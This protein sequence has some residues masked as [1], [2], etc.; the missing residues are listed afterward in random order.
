MTGFRAF[1]SIC[2]S[3]D[4]CYY[5]LQ[6][7]D[8]NGNPLGAWE[9]GLGTYTTSGNTL[10]RTTVLSS[11]NSGAAVSLPAGTTQ[12]WMDVPAALYPLGAMQ[13]GLGILMV[14]ENEASGTSGGSSTA[15]TAFTRVLKTVQA[16]TIAG[17]SLASNQVTLPAGTYIA[18]ASAPALGVDA[19]QAWLFNNTA[20]ASLLTG[21]S[22]FSLNSTPTT[23]SRSVMQGTFTLAA[24]SVLT[25]LHWTHTASANSGFG[26][27]ASSGQGEVFTQALFIKVA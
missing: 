26:R 14:Q 3:G 18:Q 9:T 12:I 15:T 21:S 19:H 20:S 7:V 13:L 16:N 8:S 6:S 27:A 17:A 2:S 5:A 1:S 25:I 4:T 10:V 22:E 11:S 24:T 23:N